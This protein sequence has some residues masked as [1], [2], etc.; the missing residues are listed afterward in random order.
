MDPEQDELQ[1]YDVAQLNS[2]DCSLVFFKRR[3][4]SGK[5]DRDARARGA[6]SKNGS[7]YVWDFDSIYFGICRITSQFYRDSLSSIGAF[8]I[9][10]FLAELSFIDRSA[11]LK[12]DARIFL[13][14]PTPHDIR[15]LKIRIWL[16]RIGMILIIAGAIL[17]LIGSLWQPHWIAPSSSKN[18]HSRLFVRPILPMKMR[19]RP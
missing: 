7:S 1:T 14:D 13:Q 8:S 10:F 9:W 15:N 4:W 19:K 3:H 11:Y 5:P 18:A 17:Q 2:L 6:I 16:S 12:G